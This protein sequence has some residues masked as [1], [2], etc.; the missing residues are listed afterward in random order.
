VH[1]AWWVSSK[2]VRTLRRRSLMV[3]KFR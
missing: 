3:L 2:H 1:R